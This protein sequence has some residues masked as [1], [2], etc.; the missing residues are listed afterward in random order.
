MSVVATS[1][2]QSKANRPNPCPRAITNIVGL[3]DVATTK[4]L[5]VA[6]R[7]PGTRLKPACP[8]KWEVAHTLAHPTDDVGP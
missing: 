3:M 4:A 7:H 6:T 8:I 5:S 1:P 2:S